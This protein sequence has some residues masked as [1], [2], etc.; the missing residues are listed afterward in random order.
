MAEQ[1]Q[2]HSQFRGQPRLPKFAIPKR[3]DLKLKPDLTAFKFAGAVQISVD[4][5][6]DTKLL[7]L[8]AAELSIKPNSVSFASH[9]KVLESV[10]I[11]LCEEDEIVVVEF[12][13]SLPIGTGF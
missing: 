2:K 10:E 3:Y 11:E 4:V 7:V 13:E 9:N 1:K 6:S 12:K 5:V 8:N